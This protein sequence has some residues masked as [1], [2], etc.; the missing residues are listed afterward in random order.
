VL[1]LEARRRELDLTQTQLADKVGAGATQRL[2][3]QFEREEAWPIPAQLQ[4]L[5]KVL[6]LPPDL[7]MKPVEITVPEFRAAEGVTLD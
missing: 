5:A 1:Y 7:V 6:H 4:R 2:I 3:S